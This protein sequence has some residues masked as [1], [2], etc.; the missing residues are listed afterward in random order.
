M[1]TAT[2]RWG[3]GRCGRNQDKVMGT[4]RRH[5]MGMGQ[6]DPD[7]MPAGDRVMGTR[8]RY[9]LG[10]WAMGTGTRNPMEPRMG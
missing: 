8:M 2:R 5:L 7:E 9:L 4:G 6:R 3:L 1:G 10:M